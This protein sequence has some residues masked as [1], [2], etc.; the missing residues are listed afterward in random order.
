[1]IDALCRDRYSYHRCVECRMR[2]PPNAEGKY[3][4]AQIPAAETK[5]IYHLRILLRQEDLSMWS[6]AFADVAELIM[7]VSVEEFHG[8]DDEGRKRV[9]RGGGEE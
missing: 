8:F 1:M 4:C 9:A 2:A 6:T 5:E 3:V 7:G